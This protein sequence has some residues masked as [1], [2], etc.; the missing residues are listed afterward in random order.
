MWSTSNGIRR[1]VD[2]AD[3]DKVW[4]MMGKTVLN[5]VR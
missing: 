4:P 3:S 2:I 5:F 1:C